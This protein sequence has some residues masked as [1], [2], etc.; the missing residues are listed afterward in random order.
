MHFAT[1]TLKLNAETADWQFELIDAFIEK[2]G[3][4]SY[5]K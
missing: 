3:R 4:P 1:L 2:V 5:R